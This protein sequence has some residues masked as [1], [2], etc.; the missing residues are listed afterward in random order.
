MGAPPAGWVAPPYNN[1]SFFSVVTPPYCYVSSAVPGANY[2]GQA[3][4]AY[5]T[6]GFGSEETYVEFPFLVG[7]I[8]RGF[9][10]GNA[11]T[12]WLFS[13]NLFPETFSFQVDLITTPF[14]AAT[15]TWNIAAGLGW[16]PFGA[17]SDLIIPNSGGVQLAAPS[18]ILDAFPALVV[19]VYGYRLKSWTF[20]V[21]TTITNVVFPQTIVS[22]A[23]MF[24]R[25]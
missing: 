2:A 22:W 21:G 1:N 11:Q 15:L 6:G 19:P 16:I 17:P 9:Y 13:P 8:V 7:D 10:F 18:I 4:V 14:S 24:A 12:E 23:A 25:P 3:S 5:M 20:G